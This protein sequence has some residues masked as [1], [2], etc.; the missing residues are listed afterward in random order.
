MPKEIKNKESEI[1]DAL[2]LMV[3]GT[4]ERT[5]ILFRIGDELRKESDRGCALVAAAYLEN[6]ISELLE[7]FFIEQSA[8]ATSA[9]FDFNG[10]VGTFSSKAKM[11][12]ALGLIP[13]EIYIAVDLIRKIRNEFAH[14]HEPL[15]FECANIKQ[16]IQNLL[17]SL[18]LQQSNTREDFIVK[19]Q[20]IAATI[21]LCIANTYPRTAPEYERVPICADESEQ[22]IEI[23]ARR[24]MKI[25]APDITYEQAIG[26]ARNF[27][28]IKN[29]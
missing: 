27:K 10:P 15:D 3:P 29:K 18:D 8:K 16:R 26:M 24:M 19:I 13:N 4:K 2:D 9:L 5:K 21:H 6:E 14:L 17:P 22:E 20:S 12:A 1:E 7:L 28:N 11:A 23:A 25:T